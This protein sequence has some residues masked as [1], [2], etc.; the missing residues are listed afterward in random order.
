[1]VLRSLS[2][3]MM[4]PIC[5]AAPADS[6]SDL[7]EVDAAWECSGSG[8]LLADAGAESFTPVKVMS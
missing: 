1:M 3:P 8:C 6:A 5:G 7:P 4:I 2:D